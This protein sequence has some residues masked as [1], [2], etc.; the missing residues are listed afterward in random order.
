ME[1]KEPNITPR[2]KKGDAFVGMA[3]HPLVF[4]NRSGV[5]PLIH[6]TQKGLFVYFTI[7]SFLV[8]RKTL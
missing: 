7:C 8:L 2:F 6:S 3:P 4:M 5:S 1:K